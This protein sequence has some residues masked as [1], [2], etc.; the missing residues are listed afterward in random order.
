LACLPRLLI[1]RYWGIEKTINTQSH[2]KINK[3]K[4]GSVFFWGEAKTESHFQFFT[5]K[6]SITFDDSG[7]NKVFGLQLFVCEG[8]GARKIRKRARKEN[9]LPKKEYSKLWR[10]IGKEKSVTF[11]ERVLWL[12]AEKRKFS[13][14]ES[15][16]YALSI[17]L[18]QRMEPKRGLECQI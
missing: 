4:Q 15:S 7:N 8:K 6:S 9:K 11:G 18:G 14:I 2:S 12:G 17:C 10:R 13:F 16:I 1:Q 3:M 5:K